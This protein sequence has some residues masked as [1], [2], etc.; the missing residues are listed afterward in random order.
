MKGICAGVPFITWPL[1]A[2]RPLNARFVTE[3]VKVGIPI[4]L[5]DTTVGGYLVVSRDEAKQ[6]V[7]ALMLENKRQELRNNVQRL[8]AESVMEGHSRTKSFTHS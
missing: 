8:R 5:K 3:A 6:A 2:D 4:S 7:R 1:N